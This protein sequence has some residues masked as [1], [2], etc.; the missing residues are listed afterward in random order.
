M[1]P[2]PPLSLLSIVQSPVIV[3]FFI[4]FVFFRD[5]FST[6]VLLQKVKVSLF[7]PFIQIYF[8]CFPPSA[9]TLIYNLFPIRVSS[10]FQDKL[11]RMFKVTAPSVGLKRD[12]IFIPS[13]QIN[14]NLKRDNF[15]HYSPKIGRAHV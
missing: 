14:N 7:L 1:L 8:T 3:V 2:Q 10:S 5:S 15:F 4:V 9:F 12:F 6:V 11:F 13:A